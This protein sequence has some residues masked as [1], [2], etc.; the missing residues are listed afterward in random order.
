VITI[1]VTLQNVPV[2][3]EHHHFTK[4]LETYCFVYS[5]LFLIWLQL[6]IGLTTFEGDR[7]GCSHSIII[8]LKNQIKDISK[9]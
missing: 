2:F 9:E 7:H 3:N 8:S 4:F 5:S 1:Q 6:D